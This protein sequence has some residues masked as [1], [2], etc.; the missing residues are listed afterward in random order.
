VRLFL[1]QFL[2]QL[3]D[4]LQLLGVGLARERLRHTQVC[5][6]GGKVESTIG[7]DFFHALMLQEN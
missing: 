7:D 6:V 4:D 3:V 1:G 2:D 5:A